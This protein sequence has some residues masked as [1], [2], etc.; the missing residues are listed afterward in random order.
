MSLLDLLRLALTALTRHRLRSL[1]SLLGV[2]IGV[3][4]VVLLTALGEGARRYVVGQF[5]SL[6]T[7]LVIVIPGKT[8]TAGALPGIGG[9]PNDLTLDDAEALRRDL[10]EV[11]RVVPV[12]VGPETVSHH[13][14]SRQVLIVGATHEY[15]DVRRLSLRLGRNLPAL[16]PSRAMPVTVLGHAVA[17]ELFADENPLGKV[18]RIADWRIRV[19]G[20]L[21][22]RG[23]SVGVDT[24]ELAI[25]PV[26]TGLRLF[27]RSSL[28]R[29]LLDVGAHAEIERVRDRAVAVIR[30]RHDDEEDVTILTED[31]VLESFS[32]I[33]AT[34]TAAVAGIAAI[35]LSV[36]GIGIMN[37]MLVSVSERTSEVG[38]LKAIG[39]THRQVLGLFLAE[40]VLLSSA[41]G[42]LGLGVALAI[43]Q[44]VGLAY[45]ELD[46][47]PP[48]WAVLAALGVSFGA[49][50]V[51]GVLPARRATRLDPVVALGKRPQ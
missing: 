8:E 18:V 28:F 15:L 10:P 42:L 14:R 1:L 31:S 37:V 50:A 34:L 19:V 13:E 7:N 20:V 2:A 40:A 39:A 9:A 45:P 44:V 21:A 32:E 22:P 29:V 4:A 48:T 25:I 17:K 41:G 46:I 12:V 49:G 38:L 51:F 26:G 6:G 33:L 35:S 23:Q 5:E 30:E 36:A 11:K 3:T 27:N 16:E 47:T 43:G 24:D